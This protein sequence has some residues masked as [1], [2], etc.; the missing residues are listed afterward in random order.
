[1]MAVHITIDGWTRAR[2]VDALAYWRGRAE[3]IKRIWRSGR[4][5]EEQQR[6]T[7]RWEYTVSKTRLAKALWPTLQT[8]FTSMGVVYG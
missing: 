5:D 8:P 2:L 4:W 6:M 7:G 1:M 3:E